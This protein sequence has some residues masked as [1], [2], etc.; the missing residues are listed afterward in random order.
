ML[1]TFTALF[2]ASVVADFV[3]QTRWMV[4]H[5]TGAGLP[6]HGGVVLATTATAA[7]S[8]AWPI[9]GLAGL[10]LVIDATKTWLMPRGAWSFLA[11]QAL[12]LASVVAI[13]AIFPSLWAQG[14]WADAPGLLYAFGAIGGAI[15]ATRAGG[16]LIPMLV[17]EGAP[18]RSTGGVFT[19]HRIGFFERGIVF[20]LVYLGSL[21]AVG[22]VVAARSLFFVFAPRSGPVSI[23][24]DFVA[25]M[26]GFLW[27]VLIG[28]GTVALLTRL[29]PVPYP[30]G[31]EALR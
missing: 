31:L 25:S 5:K 12:H 13:A 23:R 28:L 3:L 7:G 29:P 6:I 10:H 4:E 24:Q 16:F 26:A 18:R 1:E 2:F 22:L 19:A 17:P 8:L 20:V 21:W 9:F 11:D 15:L 27:A 30:T 14:V